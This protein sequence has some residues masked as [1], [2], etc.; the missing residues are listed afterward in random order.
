MDLIFVDGQSKDKTVEIAKQ[1]ILTSGIMSKFFSDNGMGLG[2]ARQAVVENTDSRYIVWV[3]ADARVFEDFVEKQV[4]FMEKNPRVCVATGRFIRRKDAHVGLPASLESLRKYVCSQAS[5]PAQGDRDIPP[6][7]TSIYRVEALK[8]VGGFDTNIRGASEDQD[9]ISR[10]RKKGWVVRV[11]DQAKCYVVSRGTWQSVWTRY[12]WYG[13]GGHFLGHK[14]KNL[15][16]L[17]YNIPLVHFLDGFR[18]GVK[19]YRLTSE[20]ESFLFPLCNAFLAA[21]RWYGYAKA[22]IEGY[23]H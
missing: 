2:V 3:D 7:D 5:F 21:G 12:V 20:R 1:A 10:M 17:M 4:E 14:T 19:A 16:F 22:H 18:L 11:N 8:Q 23:G 6:N 15:H 9:V 13:Y